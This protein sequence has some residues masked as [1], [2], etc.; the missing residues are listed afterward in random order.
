MAYRRI[1][2]IVY[3]KKITDIT[4]EAT[5]LINNYDQQYMMK[6]YPKVPI[7][8][9]FLGGVTM[10]ISSV[11]IYNIFKIPIHKYISSEGAQIAEGIVNSEKVQNI[12]KLNVSYLIENKQLNDELTK[13]V[14]ELICRDDIKDNL[15]HMFIELFD[16]NDI[17]DNLAKMCIDVIQKQEIIDAVNKLIIDACNDPINQDEIAKSIKEIISREDVRKDVSIMVRKVI[18]GS[19]FG[20]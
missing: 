19:I 2:N 10:L 12:V 6:N 13:M 7:F 20:N 3:P 11:G 9:M 17:K 14:I 8:K 18:K 1:F 16:R 4:S 5:K 15:S